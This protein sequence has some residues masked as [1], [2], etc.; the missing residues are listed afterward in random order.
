MLFVTVG[1]A[2]LI[3][4]LIWGSQYRW[5]A[6]ITSVFVIFGVLI[7]GIGIAW[8]KLG[9]TEAFLPLA[10]FGSLS[11]IAG[12]LCTFIQGIVV[13]SPS[14]FRRKAPADVPRS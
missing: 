9:A 2:S 4:G 12:Y 11:S 8:E 3:V 13:G 7:L 6:V 1:L 14:Q 5:P 10:V